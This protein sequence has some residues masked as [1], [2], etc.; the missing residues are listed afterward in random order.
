MFAAP[1]GFPACEVLP[2]VGICPVLGRDSERPLLQA[3]ENDPRST[4]DA[5][6]D[7]RT[8]SWH[9]FISRILGNCSIFAA[10]ETNLPTCQAQVHRLAS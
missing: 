8:V 9:G 2:I 1:C 4:A 7:R 3:A 5:E 10:V 6:R